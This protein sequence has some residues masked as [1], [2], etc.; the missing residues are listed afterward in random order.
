[1]TSRRYPYAAAT[2]II[3]TWFGIAIAPLD[4]TP[5]IVQSGNTV[6]A[7]DNLVIAGNTYDVTFGTT[8]DTTFGS[9]ST[10]VTALDAIL[11]ALNTSPTAEYAGAS[12]DF[13]FFV[14]SSSSAASTC[15]GPAGENTGQTLPPTWG[16]VGSNA[17]QPLSIDVPGAEFALQGG[18]QTPTGTPEPGSFSTPL[19]LGLILLLAKRRL[20]ASSR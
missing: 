11:T 15:T 16:Q 10:A 2:A 4:A 14:C 12:G 17:D 18:S 6:T 8:A 13:F 3:V 5:T 20:S 9:P 1:M 19:G 7:I